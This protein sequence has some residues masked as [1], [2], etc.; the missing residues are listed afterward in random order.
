MGEQAIISRCTSFNKSAKD[1]REV[2]PYFIYYTFL[3]IQYRGLVLKNRLQ[4]LLVSDST[5]DMAAAA[6]D[7][8]VG[9]LHDPWDMPGTAHF[10]EHM[11]FLGTEKYPSENEYSKVTLIPFK[12]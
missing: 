7:V 10:C 9:H 6:M 4:V 8:A 1:A 3:N 5:A 11:L 2:C 12:I